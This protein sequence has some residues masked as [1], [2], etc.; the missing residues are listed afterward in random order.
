MQITIELTDYEQSVLLHALVADTVTCMDLM[1]GA[2]DADRAVLEA[3]K[4]AA[5]SVYVKIYNNS[6]KATP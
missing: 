1:M 4:K 3:R 2:G 5:E 6:N